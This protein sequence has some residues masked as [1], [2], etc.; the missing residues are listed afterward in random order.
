MSSSATTR[1]RSAAWAV[2][3]P[4]IAL[5][6]ACVVAL[7]AADAILLEL[8]SNTFT[9]G[10]NG[11]ALDRA[12]LV[13]R[14][15]LGSALTDLFF[16]LA[17]WGC[18]VPLLK[19]LRAGPLQVFAL[20]AAA[21]LGI[22]VWVN[23]VRYHIHTILGDLISF[24]IM[25]ELAGGQVTAMT[26]SALPDLG[27]QALAAA[28]V[29][30][31][32][33]AVLVAAHLVERWW[34]PDPARFRPPRT[35][36]LWIGAALFG[37]LSLWPL[38]STSDAATGVRAAL[39]RKPSVAL[40][41]DLVE[42][43]TDVDRD[44]TGLLSRPPDPAP[45]DGSISPYALDLPGNGIDEDRLAGDHPVGFTGAQP[46]AAPDPAAV[47][48]SPQSARPHFLLV[49]LESF[50]NDVVGA[51]LHGR[52][53]TPNLDRLAAEGAQARFAY[54]H[55]PYTTRSRGQ[56]FGGRLDPFQGQDTLV[57]DFEA[58]GY[59]VAYFSGQDDSFGHSEGLVG[60]ARTD[61]F[62][63]A[64]HDRAR[65]TSRSTNSS[66]LQ[67]SWK[68]L[69]ERVLAFLETAHPD[70]PL[71]LYVNIVDTHFPYHHDEMDD[72]LGIGSVSRS[73]IRSWNAE[74]VWETYLNAAANVDR[75]IG[76]ITDA[77][78]AHFA[79]HDLAILVTA[80]HGQ[81]FYEKGFLGH[82]RALDE[83][84]THVP[85]ILW[86]IG[87]SWPEPVGAADLRGLL[88]E[89]L[90]RDRGG[91]PPHAR[92]APDPERQIFQYLPNPDWVH[93]LALRGL[94]RVDLYD[95]RQGR[96]RMLDAREEEV[97]APAPVREQ[98]FRQVVWNW[99]ALRLAAAARESGAAD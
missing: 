85:L 90:F 27:S 69:R 14:F 33:G 99:E 50:R 95:L 78:R 10:Y 81:A 30:G 5:L 56:L 82:G 88:A 17:L 66:S 11:V 91:A 63:D 80:D 57:D 20:T 70:V 60:A 89:N 3:G 44:G 79:G 25:W 98:R 65:R 39:E 74:R 2:S 62:Y 87:G 31:H 1:P 23:V 75:A 61:V 59:R 37:A 94:E 64:R 58:R 86:R 34:G 55:S 49:Y 32:V 48:L 97:T 35:A 38:L 96:F 8:S 43:A 18:L 84:Q 12:P 28:I 13:L 73:E 54:V 26:T 93:L 51:H 77:F 67:V 53:V 15:A 29:A 72:L 16:V 40:L 68:T 92:F 45:F 71:F 7:G 76:E 52:P 46:V 83:V 4:W 24:Q 36:L 47:A 42:Q 22:A 41:E 9:T 21:T 6:A 19:R